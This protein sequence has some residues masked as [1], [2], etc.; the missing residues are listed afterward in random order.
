MLGI[1]HAGGGCSRRAILIGGA[2]IHAASKELCARDVVANLVNIAVRGSRIEAEV[3]ETAAET[4][5]LILDLHT[6]LAFLTAV[7]CGRITAGSARAARLR[8]VIGWIRYIALLFVST[9]NEVVT[10]A[11]AVAAMR[12]DHV[13]LSRTGLERDTRVAGMAVIGGRATSQTD[14]CVVCARRKTDPSVSFAGLLRGALCL[15]ARTTSQT[16]TGICGTVGNGV[17]FIADAGV[18][19]S[20]PVTTARRHVARDACS[21][22]APCPAVTVLGNDPHA[23]TLRVADAGFE[24]EIAKGVA[25]ITFRTGASAF[26]IELTVRA[27][28]SQDLELELAFFGREDESTHWDTEGV[29]TERLG[30][31]RA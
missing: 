30:T 21:W 6:R 17:A 10:N 3:V 22:S 4:V 12:T 5:A 28:Q 25:A 27:A 8:F 29:G 26:G 16:T 14:R 11:E 19:R 2:G 7:R 1:G 15:C 31:L 24:T 23:L 13:R 20:F 9:L 18:G